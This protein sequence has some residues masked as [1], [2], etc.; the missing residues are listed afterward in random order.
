[1]LPV[2][3][4]STARFDT[5]ELVNILLDPDLKEEKICKTQPT[6][7]EH[8]TVFVVDISRLDCI[9]DLGCDDMGSWKCNGVYHAWVDVDS[10]GFVASHGK[11]KPEK[12]TS[13]V[14]M[15][16]KKCYVHK[17]SQDLKKTI[18]F[19]AGMLSMKYLDNRHSN[20]IQEACKSHQCVRIFIK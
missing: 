7:I 18:V 20:L 13:N 2:Y 19:L 6:D 9:K 4:R 16:T 17:T 8:N 15:I 5:Q 1:M 12:V 11:K 10:N 3:S 14:Y